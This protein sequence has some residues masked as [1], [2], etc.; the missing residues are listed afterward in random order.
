VVGI[1][2]RTV[3]CLLSHRNIEIKCEKLQ[4]KHCKAQEFRAT[5]GFCS[6]SGV[7]PIPW[8]GTSILTSIFCHPWV[9]LA[10]RN[11]IGGFQRQVDHSSCHPM[12]ES[13]H[14]PT[15]RQCAQHTRLAPLVS[16]SCCGDRKQTTVAKHPCGPKQFQ[17]A[18][19]QI[20]DPDKGSLAQPTRRIVTQTY[21]PPFF[22][23]SCPNELFPQTARKPLARRNAV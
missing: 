18:G 6:R 11:M 10:S 12:K 8:M 4:Q 23:P 3:L 1:Q 20:Q 9:V 15:L 2:H 22:N 19:A 14:R 17:C 13:L 7:Q 5:T 21:N 16:R